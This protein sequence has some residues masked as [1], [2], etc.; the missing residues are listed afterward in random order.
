M[1]M[2]DTPIDFSVLVTGYPRSGTSM[3]MRMCVAAGIPA[4]ASDKGRL[5]LTVNPYGSL[6]L[7]NVGV[8]LAEHSPS[9]TTGRVVKLVSPYFTWFPPDRPWRA[10]FMLRDVNEVL[11]SLISMRT[12]YELN[13]QDA[14]T[15]ALHV[16]RVFSVPT[17]FLHYAEV[18]KYPKSASLSLL[19]FLDLP[20]SLCHDVAAVVDINAREK[21]IREGTDRKEAIRAGYGGL[22]APSAVTFIPELSNVSMDADM[23]AR[24]ANAAAITRERVRVALEKLK[25]VSHEETRH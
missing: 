9:W 11:A 15:L 7:D 17:L 25:E 20:P 2:M 24:V 14:N 3:A 13:Y 4:L 21:G 12:I 5:G 22:V 6:E 1:K 10:I 18:R 23:Y 19:E 8:D 16:L